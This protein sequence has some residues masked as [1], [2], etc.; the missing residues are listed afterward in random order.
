[1]EN[2]KNG[3]WIISKEIR[4]NKCGR[5]VDKTKPLPEVCPHCSCKMTT[6]VMDASVFEFI[7]AWPI[8]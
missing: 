3:I 4:C 2:Y 7:H 5:I 1:M 6:Q 8:L